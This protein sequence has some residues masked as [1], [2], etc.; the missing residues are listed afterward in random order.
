MVMAAI[1]HLDWMG[2]DQDNLVNIVTRYNSSPIE[3][4]TANYSTED[5]GR[6]LDG[7]NARDSVSGEETFRP[8]LPDSELMDGDQNN[9]LVTDIETWAN[10]IAENNWGPENYEAL[11]LNMLS[12]IP[13]VNGKS[14]HSDRDARDIGLV[15]D[16]EAIQYIG[17]CYNESA[18]LANE[19]SKEGLEIEMSTE[20]VRNSGR[21]VGVTSGE[22]GLEV[23]TIYSQEEGREKMREPVEL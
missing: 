5:G 3:E 8:D 19:V 7:M 10:S 15:L 14:V 20:D 2:W 4:I 1:H 13:G 23:D 6:N 12:V 22:D 17:E 16:D 11:R 18:D 21:Y 9:N